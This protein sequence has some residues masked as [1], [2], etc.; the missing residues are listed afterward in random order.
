MNK[1]SIAK[2]DTCYYAWP[3]MAKLNDDSLFCVFTSCNHHNDRNNSLLMYTVS[4]DKG[5]NWSKA[6][7]FTELTQSNYFYNNARVRNLGDR[8]VL[9]CDMVRKDETS[10]KPADVF[11]WTSFDN[12][13]TWSTPVLT[14]ACGIVPDIFQTK[15]G[16]WILTAHRTDKDTKKLIQYCYISKD[17]G[18]T[19]SQEITVAAD[20]RYNL[21]ETSI[22]ECDD[23]TLVAYMRE[24]SFMGY[25]CLKT[26]SQDGGYTWSEVYNVPVPGCHRPTV[27]HLNNGNVLITYRFHHGSTW[28]QGTSGLTMLAVTD[29]KS[30]KE[31]KRLDQWTRI[32][33]IDFDRHNTADGGYTDWVQFDDGTIYIVNYIKDDHDKGQI[34]GYSLKYDEIQL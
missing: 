26:I 9:V 15:S 11:M 25:D 29:E 5:E 32:M 22:L 30:A 8:V 2:S 1:Y 10:E 19:W 34:R 33:P 3:T 12:A 31:S 6:L 4:T 23:G 18:Q 20:T 17:K 28:R 16:N 7:P 14:P 27:G 21:C 24:N 13:K